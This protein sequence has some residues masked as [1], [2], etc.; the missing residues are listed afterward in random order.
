MPSGPITPGST[1][2][3]TPDSPLPNK[4]ASAVAPTATMPVS[5]ADMQALTQIVLNT[6]RPWYHVFLSTSGPT[7]YLHNNA[8]YTDVI[9]EVIPGLKVG[10]VVEAHYNAIGY[11]PAGSGFN[12]DIDISENGGGRIAITKDA[13]FGNYPG[14]TPVALNLSFAWQILVAGDFEIFVKTRT[15]NI[16]NAVGIWVTSRILRVNRNL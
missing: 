3:I 7:E 5:G 4:Y 6:Q 8:T 2:V 16:A 15:S 12:A 10:D 14:S 1:V 13:P 11:C 9:D